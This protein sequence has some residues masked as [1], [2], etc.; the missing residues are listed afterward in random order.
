M[1]RE[2]EVEKGERPSEGLGKR[3]PNP[4]DLQAHCLLSGPSNANLPPMA[5]LRF[6]YTERESPS[7]LPP[8]ILSALLLSENSDDV[9]GALKETSW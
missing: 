6:I 9:V 8:L 4:R 7:S 1:G 3:S 5:P 2:R